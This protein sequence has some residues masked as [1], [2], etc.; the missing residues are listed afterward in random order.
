MVI[1]EMS[2][3]KRE[4]TVELT[5][6]EL[7]LLE[8]ALYQQYK[9]KNDKNKEN[10]LK[11][12]SDV[13]TAENLC[14]YGHIDNFALHNIVK[15]RNDVGEGLDGVLSDKDIDVFNSYLED[16][17]MPTAFGNTDW[18]NVY[19]KIVGRHGKRNAGYKLKSWMKD[20]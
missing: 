19:S 14:Q 13:I 3:E 6:D 4:V 5:A 15:L 11:L 8:N 10:L 20:C 18:D 12:Y 7:V 1:K 17:D 16:N 2:K 9:I